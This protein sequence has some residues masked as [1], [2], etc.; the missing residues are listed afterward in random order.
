M[1][2]E[3]G[4][5]RPNVCN[6][7][8]KQNNSM[9]IMLICNC[10]CRCCCCCCCCRSVV[11][12]VVVSVQRF[13]RKICANS[14]P[15][16]SLASSSYMQRESINLKFM[17]VRI[18]AGEKLN[19]RVECKLCS[20]WSLFLSCARASANKFNEH[21]CWRSRQRVCCVCRRRRSTV[22]GIGNNDS[23][24]IFNLDWLRWC[25]VV[26]RSRFVCVYRFAVVYTVCARACA[27]STRTVKR[28]I[29]HRMHCVKNARYRRSNSSAISSLV[30]PRKIYIISTNS[31]QRCDSVVLRA[32]KFE[33]Y[34]FKWHWTKFNSAKWNRNRG[35]KHNQTKHQVII[36]FNCKPPQSRRGNETPFN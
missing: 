8:E 7:N 26:F 24:G 31:S 36:F 14:S 34:W 22:A 19:F 20:D 29:S 10:F 1:D 11:P 28:L 9:E 23:G 6:V 30:A 12:V 4:D 18:N 33:A 32:S 13:R 21:H 2:F 3:M 16:P 17:H 5:H 25:S 15:S 35:I 27:L